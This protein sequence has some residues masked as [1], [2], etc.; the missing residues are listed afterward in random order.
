VAS[1][2]RFGVAQVVAPVMADSQILLMA[3]ATFAQG[4]DVF[5]RG[6]RVRHMGPAHPTRHHAMQLAGDRFVNFV[7][8]EL[9]AAQGVTPEKKPQ[10]FTHGGYQV[11]PRARLV[12]LRSWL[13]IM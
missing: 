10:L 3:I 11:R 2:L 12:L 7:A 13:L 8:G 1:G 4:L 9:E 5:Q 6:L